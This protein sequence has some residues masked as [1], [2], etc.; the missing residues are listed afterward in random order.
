[1][2]RGIQLTM[3]PCALLAAL[4]LSVSS[5]PDAPPLTC[6]LNDA[7]LTP[8]S[9]GDVADQLAGSLLAGLC[10]KNR[11]IF[12]T[13][14]GDGHVYGC[15]KFPDAWANG[16]VRRSGAPWD[17]NAVVV[18]YQAGNL[19]ATE[20][21][22]AYD[23]YAA[24]SYTSSVGYADDVH[25][26]DAGGL[27]RLRCDG[28]GDDARGPVRAAT[29]N[30]LYVD[31]DLFG[32]VAY[33]AEDFRA[34]AALGLNA[35]RVPVPAA[36]FAT[37]TSVWAET[38]YS[39][40]QDCA[41][42]GVRGF[43]LALHGA[44]GSDGVKHAVAFAQTVAGQFAGEVVGVEVDHSAVIDADVAAAAKAQ[45]IRL[46]RRVADE[47]ELTDLGDGEDAVAMTFLR[48]TTAVDVA[49]SD[50]AEDRGKL[51]YH[52]ALAC[53]AAAPLGFAACARGAPVFASG[54]DLSI[55][56]CASMGDDYGQCDNLD[57]RL[58]SP[59][60]RRHYWSLSMRSIAAFEASGLG[61]AWHRWKV[62]ETAKVHG[63]VA[64]ALAL[65]EAAALSWVPEDLS[66]VPA[67][68]CLRGPDQDAAL[69]DAT[70]APTAGATP[71]PGPASASPLVAHSACDPPLHEK[72]AYGTYGAAALLAAVATT[73][74]VQK[75]AAAAPYSPVDTT[76]TSGTTELS[77]LA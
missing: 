36:F 25:A 37:P 27:V 59:W 56:D 32:S 18:Q 11:G 34:M 43:V 1:M 52:E 23:A 69:G 15:G 3:R 29:L 57:D 64:G 42:A 75:R 20:A 12:V 58:A 63:A 35:A 67:A 38:L 7:V 55:D 10:G 53:G 6:G 2:A 48:S 19:T 62:P 72:V 66:A 50:P 54:F 17:A 24:L 4:A 51:V 46:A 47:A 61:W 22:A 68:T 73:A 30:G 77:G 76:A 26:C 21:W 31:D 44:H 33:G 8:S 9:F 5:A 70:L 14:P 40:L 74:V 39:T 28:Y 71:A 65:R 49:S 13:A 41:N 60:W 45:R 16:K